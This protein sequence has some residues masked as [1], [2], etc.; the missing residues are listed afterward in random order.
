M[1]TQ[2]KQQFGAFWKTQPITT[3][4]PPNSGCHLSLGRTSW[5]YGKILNGQP[6]TTIASGSYSL[7]AG[8][9]LEASVRISGNTATVNLPDGTV[10]IITDTDIGTNAGPWATIEAFQN[11]A[12]ADDRTG[13]YKS[14]LG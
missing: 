9:P 10:Q 13:F 6:V 11:D 4:S 2:R 8:V 3:A 12:A 1:N 7:S 5:I 14:W